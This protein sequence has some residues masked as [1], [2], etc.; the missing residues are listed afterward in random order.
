MQQALLRIIPKYLLLCGALLLAMGAK[1][2]L[3][4][5][6]SAINFVDKENLLSA[7]DSLQHPDT[8]PQ[9]FQIYNPLYRNEVAFLSQGNIVSASQPLIFN[10]ERTSGF[11]VG[12]WQ[13]YN[14]FLF[15][16]QNVRMYKVRKAYTDLFYTQGGEEFLKLKA[17]HTQNIKP[18][19]N[20]GL[21]LNRTKSNGVQKRQ[22][23]GVYNTR[24]FNWYHSRDERYHLIVTATWNRLRNEE[25]G[26]ITNDTFF[27]K[28]SAL[29]QYPVRLGDDIDKVKN[30]IK[31]NDYR[32]T[33]MLRL[34]PKKQLKYTLPEGG[35]TELD[36][37]PTLVPTYVLTYE[38]AY[39][40]HRYIFKDDSYDTGQYY[41]Y[42]LFND[43]KTHD[44]IQHNTLSNSFTLSTAPFMGYLR[45]TMPVKRWIQMSA[46]AGYDAHYISWQ[47]QT[48]ANYYNTYVGGSI[49][50]NPFIKSTIQFKANGLFWLTGYNQ[51]DYKVKGNVDIDLGL[52]VLEG[53]ALF[54][55]Y[56][57][58]ITQFFFLGNHNY[59]KNDLNKSFVNSISAGIRTKRF[60]N[61]YHITFK[62]QLLNNYIYFDSTLTARQEARAISITSVNFRKRFKYGKFYL[63]NNITIQTTNNSQILRIPTVAT[64]NSLYFEG[65]LFKKALYAQIGTD[66]FYY[67]QI[68]PT[69]FD[70]ETRQFYIQNNVKMGSYPWFDV[71][72]S[73]HVRTFS[74]YLKMEHVT[75]GF[76]GRRYYASPHNPHQG[77]VF[78]IGIAWKFFD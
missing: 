50:S 67:S 32:V 52:F 60:K 55:A 44:S 14:H 9:Y 76:F 16:Q 78:R 29:S 35:T 70:P 45:D 28:S 11:D 13:A 38:F 24:L 68:T 61:N 10:G 27:E 5:K 54:Q 71:F 30:I 73:G 42:T 66:F 58:N 43:E 8:V 26:G 69:T 65:Y 41:P 7:I 37:V 1:S 53:G 21:E 47:N 74:F 31:T 56:E 2:Q 12:V 36:T 33:N 77:R 22:K 17:L 40:Q 20:I 57:P 59:W 3:T 39:S 48:H 18:N 51:G 6:Y 19:W 23:A 62:Q 4:E 34:G 15:S 64:Y 46:T 75:Q 25:N 49:F 72:L 63:D